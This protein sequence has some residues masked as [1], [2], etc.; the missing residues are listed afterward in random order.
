[1]VGHS[2]VGRI[3]NE[4][5]ASRLESGFPWFTPARNAV[6]E[7]ET[8]RACA[9]AGASAPSR[10]RLGCLFG[11]HSMRIRSRGR[12]GAGGATGVL[13]LSYSQFKSA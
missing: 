2:E 8:A 11:A 4:K 9:Y 1:M 12:S 13:L 6:P 7:T 10:S 3:R 5:S